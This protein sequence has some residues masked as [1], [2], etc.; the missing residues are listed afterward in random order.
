MKFLKGNNN[1]LK[2]IIEIGQKVAILR[3]NISTL[4]C[5]FY[6]LIFFFFVLSNLE[7]MKF[8]IKNYYLINYANKMITK[9]F[10]AIFVM[11]MYT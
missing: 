9:W 4:T 2:C 1:K 10:N 11:Y 7:N 5:Y 8:L 6:F 3:Q